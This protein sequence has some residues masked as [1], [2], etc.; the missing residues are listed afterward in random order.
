MLSLFGYKRDLEFSTLF[1]CL[2]RPCVILHHC[3]YTISETG[4]QRKINMEEIDDVYIFFAELPSLNRALAS[5]YP[6][7]LIQY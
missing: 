4:K 3:I 6:D 2:G 7:F 1:L 5:W